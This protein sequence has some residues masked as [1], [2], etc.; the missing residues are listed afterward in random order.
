MDTLT[1]LIIALLLL[2]NL[3]FLYAQH[4]FK[5]ERIELVKMIAAKDYPQYKAIEGANIPDRHRSLIGEQQ[6][7]MAKRKLE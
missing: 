1:G 6:K 5:A 2:E 7:K 3:Y 4:S